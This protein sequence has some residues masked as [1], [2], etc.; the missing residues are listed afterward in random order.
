MKTLIIA[1]LL[2]ASMGV[3]AAKLYVDMTRVHRISSF[4]VCMG[5]TP[6]HSDLFAGL[7]RS[8][9]VV[10]VHSGESDKI[11]G[12]EVN[13]RVQ[14]IYETVSVG[15]IVMYCQKVISDAKI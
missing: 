8:L 1:A 14:Y 15:A 3:G 11:L 7:A 5:I 2:T 9:I 6:S 13:K 10:A 12:R 4:M